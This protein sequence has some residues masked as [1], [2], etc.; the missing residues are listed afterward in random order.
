M[1]G[2]HILNQN[3]LVTGSIAFGKTLFL[4]E[5]LMALLTKKEHTMLLTSNI[6]EFKTPITQFNGKIIPSTKIIDNIDDSLFQI[7]EINPFS[8]SLDEVN[9]SFVEFVNSF[10]TIIQS[11]IKTVMIDEGMRLLSEIPFPLFI[12]F[13]ERLNEKGV[14]VIF[15]SLLELNRLPINQFMVMDKLFPCVLK[16]NHQYK[17]LANA[18]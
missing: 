9:H 8:V 14:R 18:S 5:A 13:V 11:E 10:E 3:L 7:V 16:L 2:L 12:K 6:N 15:T 17:P 1:F 4:K